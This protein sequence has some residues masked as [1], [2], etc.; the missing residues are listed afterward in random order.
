MQVIVPTLGNQAIA[1]LK[2]SSLVSVL[3]VS[4]LLYSAE[5]IYGRNYQTIPLLVV[6]CIWYLAISTVLAV[7]Q[8]A[9]ERS[10]GRSTRAA[11][12]T[13]TAGP[14]EILLKVGNE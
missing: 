4:E 13:L 11:L 6:A 1:M 14:E 12:G 10:Y 2:N 3:G 9:I 5:I 8:H 7:M